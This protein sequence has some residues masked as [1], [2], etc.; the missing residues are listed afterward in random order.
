M[1]QSGPSYSK[2][3]TN[4]KLAIN[5]L[6]LL[7]KKKSEL[8]LKA[9]KEIADYISNGKEERARI[10]VEHIIREDYLVEGMEILE[11][12]C[13]LLLARF[14]LIQQMKTLDEGMAEPIS[15]I[16]WAAPRLQTEIIELKIIG[17]QLTHKYGKPYTQAV[18]ENCLKTVNEKLMRKLGVEAPPKLLVERYMIE[19]AK[20]HNVPFEPDPEIMRHDEIM[21]AEAIAMNIPLIDFENL[22]KKGG[23]NSGGGGYGGNSG[24]GG[25]YGGMSAPPCWIWIRSSCPIQLP[26]GNIFVSI[27]FQQNNQ[28]SVNMPPVPQAPPSGPYPPGS[29]GGGGFSAHQDP[30]PSYNSV[31]NKGPIDQKFPPPPSK[32]I[33]TLPELPSVPMNSLPK[34]DDLPPPGSNSAEDPDFDDLARRFEDLKK[35]K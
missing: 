33:N 5:R 34:L 18:R 30:T 17:D 31:V 21:A 7:E 8:A 14:G 1:F 12:Y 9:R 35:R 4:L 27:Q 10:R 32:P 2:L 16:I 25:G 26:S 20:I 19:I 23:G 22:D 29:I 11:M 24:G 6:K 13:D 28:A 15:S 3:K